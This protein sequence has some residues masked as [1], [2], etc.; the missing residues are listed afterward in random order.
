MKTLQDWFG[1]AKALGYGGVSMHPDTVP[2][3]GALIQPSG[4]GIAIFA[5]E[6]EGPKAGTVVFD[7]AQARAFAA[8]I[9]AAA[10]VA[11]K[12]ADDAQHKGDDQ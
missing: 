6:S 8:A 5:F 9:L 10:D 11:Q 3:N 4:D 12:S 7:L 1:V 2:G